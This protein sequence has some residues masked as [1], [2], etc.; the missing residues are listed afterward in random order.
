M[1][2]LGGFGNI[3]QSLLDLAEDVVFSPTGYLDYFWMFGIGQYLGTASSGV[4]PRNYT[5]SFTMAGEVKDYKPG[6]LI[7]PEV[8]VPFDAVYGEYT[9]TLS[10]QV[11]GFLGFMQTGIPAPLTLPYKESQEVLGIDLYNN[12][13]RPMAKQMTKTT[14]PTLILP[15][16]V[17]FLNLHAKMY[18]YRTLTDS[19]IFPVSQFTDWVNQPYNVYTVQ[20]NAQNL[21]I[22][23]ASNRSYQN[24]D[25]SSIPA[26]KRCLIWRVAKT[27][28][29]TAKFIPLTALL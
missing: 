12:Y 22:T 5:P 17:T 27:F 4:D 11:H 20:D 18:M 3:S 14:A 7:L 15:Q 8:Q 28:K 10:V 26:N 6:F 23:F 9:G 16:T 19:S 25:L 24:L 2:G 21:T 1:D 13:T 29:I